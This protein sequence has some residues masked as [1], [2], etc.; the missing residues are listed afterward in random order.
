MD[1]YVRA[2]RGLRAIPLST[3][4]SGKTKNIFTG[5]WAIETTQKF[6]EEMNF[7]LLTSY[8]GFTRDFTKNYVTRAFQLPANQQWGLFW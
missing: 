2:T 8:G 1:S 5:I 7:L 6:I 4:N 3:P